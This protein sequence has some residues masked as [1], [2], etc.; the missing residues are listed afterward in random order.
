MQPAD[1]WQQLFESWPAT[2]PAHGIVV[3]NYH[4][5]I[6]FV[7]FMINDGMVVLERDKPDSSDARKVILPYASISALKITATFDL[8]RFAELGFR[9]VNNEM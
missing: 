2:F 7:N 4:E 9:V 5:S 8:D 3:T 6:P 1:Y